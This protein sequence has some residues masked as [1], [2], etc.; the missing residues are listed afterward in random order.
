ML[1]KYQVACQS[2]GE[3][4]AYFGGGIF[5]VH[6]RFI[7]HRSAKAPEEYTPDFT[8]YGGNVWWQNTRLLYQ[9]QL[10]REI[11]IS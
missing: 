10:R 8:A 5:A 6:P 2:R 4:P 7:G 9:F 1:H 11:S 3:L